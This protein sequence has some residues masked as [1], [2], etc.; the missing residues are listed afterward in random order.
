MKYPATVL[1]FSSQF[2]LSYSIREGTRTYSDLGTCIAELREGRMEEPV[3]FSEWLNIGVGM[4]FLSLEGHV[5]VGDFWDR[6]EV[7]DDG[8]EEYEACNCQIHPL[9]ILECAGVIGG[10]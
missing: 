1:V 2:Q 9:D 8:E 7:E 3:L 10:F 6:R 4:G 5:C